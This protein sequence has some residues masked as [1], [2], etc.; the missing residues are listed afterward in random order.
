M[1]VN[2]TKIETT[3]IIGL[4]MDVQ[5]TTCNVVFY[6]DLATYLPT[7]PINISLAITTTLLNINIERPLAKISRMKA[8]LCMWWQ[9]RKE[10]R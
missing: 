10:F 4:L 5:S 7:I 8:N 9:R 1:A 2:S 3:H 6:V